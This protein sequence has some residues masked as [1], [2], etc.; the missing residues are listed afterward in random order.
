MASDQIMDMSEN[1][2]RMLRGEL[3]FAFTEELV[4]GRLSITRYPF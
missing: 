3:Y 1:K 4:A 2:Q